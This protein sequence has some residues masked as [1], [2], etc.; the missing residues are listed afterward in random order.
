MARI[1]L[2]TLTIGALLAGAFAP[3]PDLSARPESAA[4]PT[5]ACPLGLGPA[6]DSALLGALEPDPT[7]H[8]DGCGQVMFADLHAD[9]EPLKGMAARAKN[10]SSAK[11]LRYSKGV[12]A[13][14]LSSR[15][16]ADKTIYIDFTGIQLEG[17][18]WN[19][20]AGSD[21]I[22]VEPWSLDSDPA[23]LT[24]VERWYIHRVWQ[25]VVEDF[26]AFD[27]NV[28][29]AVPEKGS[30]ARTS[31]ADPRY[32]IR[33][34]ISNERPLGFPECSCS[35]AALM[36]SFSHLAPDNKSAPSVFAF[37]RGLS[38]A[39][40]DQLADVISHEVGHSLGLLHSGLHGAEYASG[41]G[42][43]GPLMGSGGA[44]RTTWS[45]GSYPGA[46]NRQDELEVIAR[47]LPRIADDHGNE[48]ETASPW[49]A[50]NA[51]STIGAGDDI[52]VFKLNISRESAV[53]ILA[54]PASLSP[55]VH[56]M[57]E[58]VTR[59]GE[60]IARAESPKPTYWTSTD[61][62]S[63][64][65]SATL[66]PGNYFVKVSSVGGWLLPFNGEPLSSAVALSSYG[67]IGVY[68]LSKTVKPKP[69]PKR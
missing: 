47:T 64:R 5:A 49:P 60:L 15:P 51:L 46:A 8:I 6:R 50:R 61:M 9:A 13:L 42:N 55:N 26:A 40:A 34:I 41:D 66:F 3:T 18:L 62:F 12:N 11:G 35:G 48:V 20:V 22:T 32:G 43:W 44:R 54:S 37:F 38:P 68:T 30:L 31:M 24:A 25:A 14:A 59:S 1:A 58:L 67:S 19:K 21:T 7:A 28:T 52:D 33:V 29:T 39:A 10:I 45:D 53:V 57:L 56:L 16:Q 69:K 2:L 36:G 27:V 63:S 23:S 65:I 17:S 4:D